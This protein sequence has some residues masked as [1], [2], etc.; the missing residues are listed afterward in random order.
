MVDVYIN[1]FQKGEQW[2]TKNNKQ[3]RKF[4]EYDL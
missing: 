4:S 3:T 1:L 2:L